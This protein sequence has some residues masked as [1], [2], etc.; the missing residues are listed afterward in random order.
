MAL[1]LRQQIFPSAGRILYQATANLSTAMEQDFVLLERKGDKG[2]ITLNRHKALNAINLDMGRTMANQLRSWDSDNDIKMVMIKSSSEKAFCA[3]GDVKTISTGGKE[4]GMRF[5]R[6]EYTLNN[7]IGSL[8]VPYVALV[9]GIVMGGGVGLSV[10]GNFRV[11]TEKALF[12]MPETAI[13]LFPDVGASNFLNKLPGSLGLY[14]GLTGERL[15]GRDLFK[16]GIGTHFIP[17][18]KIKT[19]EDELMRIEKPDL[20]K[21]DRVLVKYQQ[22]WEDDYR[23]E[24]TLKPHIGRINSVFGQANS[25]E[26]IMKGLEKDNSEWARKHLEILSRMSPTSL[27]LT[28]EQLKRGKSMTLSECLKM[29]FRMAARVLEGTDFYEGVRAVL[30]EKDNKPNWNPAKL[31]DVTD[32]QIQAYFE[33]LPYQEELQL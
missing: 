25:V 11:V 27:K 29:E 28:F 15:K 2:V 17:S 18:D 23:K 33:N 32:A 22:Q 19:L 3:G 12:A 21:I 6:Q 9:D 14:F 16:A 20:L 4:G 1:L 30:V 26:D 5:F 24:F 8:S 7:L 13:G 31:E 10:H